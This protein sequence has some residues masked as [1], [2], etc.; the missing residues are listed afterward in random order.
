MVGATDSLFVPEANG[1]Y[2][3]IITDENGCTAQSAPV[4]YGSVGVDERGAS[5]LLVY[6]QPATDQLIV[7]GVPEGALLQLIDAAGRTVLTKSANSGERVTLDVSNLSAG[8]YIV[9]VRAGQGVQRVQV[10]VE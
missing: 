6:P 2:S 9:E 3:V 5:T 10:V 8:S 4:Y 1:N 7:R